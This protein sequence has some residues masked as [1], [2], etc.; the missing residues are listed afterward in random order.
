MLH[1]SE[2]WA[3]SWREQLGISDINSQ[4]FDIDSVATYPLIDQVITSGAVN[5]KLYNTQANNIK[6]NQQQNLLRLSWSENQNFRIIID[7]PDLYIVVLWIF[8]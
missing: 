6:N 2:G 1:S 5:I 8:I 7:C 3:Q 4:N